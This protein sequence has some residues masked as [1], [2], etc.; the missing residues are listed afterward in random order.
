MGMDTRIWAILGLALALIP[1]S[2]A[3]SQV[4]SS[5]NAP[6]T[7]I[8]PFYGILQYIDYV[9]ITRSVVL[10]PGQSITIQAPLP[11]GPGY[12]FS[13]VVVNINPPTLALGVSGSGL[14]VERNIVGAIKSVTS[15]AGKLT[16]TNTGDKPITLNLLIT[17]VFTKE[18]YIPLPTSQQF[19]I[20]ITIPDDTAQYVS[21]QFVKFRIDNYMPY[22][23]LGASLPNGTT[24]SQLVS[25]WSN[26]ANYIKIEPK[27]VQLDAKNLPP[28]SYAISLGYGNEYTMPSAM[29]IKGTE[30]INATVNPGQYME[31]TGSEFGVP[32][33]WGLLGYI[34][35]VYTVQPL[36]VGQSP[37]HFEVVANRVSPVSTYSSLI[38]VSGI[39]YLLPPFIRFAPMVGIYVVYDR[40]FKIV[41]NLNVPLVVTYMPILYKGVGNWV[42]GNLQATV[43]DT[44]VS[45]GLWSAL[46]VQL[47]EIANIYRIT[48]PSGVIYQGLINSEVPWGS[49]V[50]L[51]SISPDAQQAYVAVSTLGISEVGTY[52]FYINWTPVGMLIT[53]TAGS[54]I[55]GVKVVGYIDD[56]PVSSA[57]SNDDGYVGISIKEPEP[58][59]ASI[60]YQGVTVYNV[61][62]NSLIN[63]PLSITIGLFNVT[64][65][66]IGARNQAIPN[67]NITLYRIGTGPYYSGITD[68]LGSVTM[69]N[70]LGGTYMVT[71]QYGRLR[72]TEVITIND[73]GVITIKSDILAIVAGV[74]IT[75]TEALIG[76]L[77]LGGAAATA[78]A[79]ANR[80][81]GR[82]Y[83]IVT[84]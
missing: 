15:T 9:N 65:L 23:V 59:T 57:V 18:Q 74:P 54:P 76:G 20:N 33:G 37:G 32:Q 6:A 44:D 34:V 78:F 50:R 12:V 67:G 17:Y 8:Q 29:L 58:F 48:T 62:I 28:G 26:L 75:T 73:N 30:F 22:Q 46:V 36:V 51:V 72:Y 66:F 52:T 80:R 53:N 71:A 19:T 84:M 21:N 56:T 39:S 82:D 31:I 55:V 79:F 27:Y 47:P 45:G 49:G 11:P 35:V 69:S 77:G 70:V 24:L 4:S 41:D 68:N 38:E 10:T 3:A 81:R 13:Q 2:I 5:V 14:Y 63:Q 16:L 64:V 7:I 60:S 25:S 42:N 61:R 1:I 43:T 40:Y 83:E